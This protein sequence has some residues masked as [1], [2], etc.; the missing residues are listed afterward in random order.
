MDGF[1][2]GRD[3]DWVGL[4]QR[5]GAVATELGRRAAEGYREGVEET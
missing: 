5:S 2:R 3:V 4:A 1:R